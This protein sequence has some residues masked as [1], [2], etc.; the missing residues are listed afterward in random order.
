MIHVVVPV[1][2]RVQLTLNCIKSL[3]KQNINKPLNIIIVNDG[4]TDD[5]EKYVKGYYPEITILKGNGNLFWGGAVNLGINYVLNIKKQQDWL[6]LVNND[7][8]LKFDAITKLIEQSINHKR[9]TIV[10]AL[11]INYEDKKTI[12]KSG[13]IVENWFLNRT[14][15]I[16]NN[17]SLDQ[18]TNPESIKVD[19]ITARCLL[20]PIEIFEVAG[21]YD[22]NNFRHYGADDEF[23]VRI[24]KFG[25]HSFL[26]PASI[27]YLKPNYDYDELKNSSKKKS[28]LFALF[29][30][31]SSLNIIN[32]FRLSIKVVP[33][34]AKL[35]FF[36]I[37]CLKSLYLYFFK[38]INL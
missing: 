4:S 33:H 1:H 30:I 29:S 9:K 14:R 35:S 31:H 36:L 28:I 8:E 18:I 6:L 27:V 15:H 21:N 24:K 20:H 16:Y 2:N 37:G 11:S 23:S 13:T 25:Y 32:K 7:V 22:S 26:C 34:Y 10:G 19:F 3:K 38:K 12:I 5:T 17:M